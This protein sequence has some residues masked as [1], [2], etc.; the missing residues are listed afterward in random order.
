MDSG[1]DV[2]VLMIDAAVMWKPEIRTFFLAG[3]DKDGVTLARIQQGL[4]FRTPSVLVAVVAKRCNFV[5]W[6]SCVGR[7][8]HFH[9]LHQTPSM[10]GCVDQDADLDSTPDFDS[11]QAGSSS[12]LAPNVTLGAKQFRCTEVSFQRGYQCNIKCVVYIRMELSVMSCFHV[13]RTSSNRSISAWRRNRRRYTSSCCVI[14]VYCRLDHNQ[15]VWLLVLFL[16]ACQ[17]TSNVRQVA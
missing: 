4:R 13:A 8:K 5:F 17:W 7:Q 6:C 10:H 1:D 14:R 2:F 16:F 9:C 12:Q 15:Q 11:S 3:I